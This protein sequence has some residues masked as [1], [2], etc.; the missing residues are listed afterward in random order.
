MLKKIYVQ[1]FSYKNFTSKIENAA[2]RGRGGGWGDGSRD[3]VSLASEA[4]S[5]KPQ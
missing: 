1:V 4:L 3:S 2:V 5:S